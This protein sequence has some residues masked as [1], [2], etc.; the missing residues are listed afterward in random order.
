MGTVHRAYDTSL[1]RP[2]A[3]KFLRSDDPDRVQRFLREAQAQARVEHENVCRVYESGQKDG[4][5]YIAMQL[6]DGQP[7]FV[8]D[9]EASRPSPTLQG[10]SVEQKV[11]LMQQIAEAIQA[12]HREGLIHR[13]I[14]PSNI[15]L[16]RH[17]DGRLQPYVLDFGLARE[18][19]AAGVTSLGLA[20]GTPNFMSPEQARGE[21]GALDRRTDV[22][23]LGATLYAL[24]AGAPPFEGPS[25]LDVL[26]KVTEQDAPP[27]RGVPDDLATIVGKCLQKDPAH[28]YDSARALAEDL[29]RYLDGEPIHARKTSLAY[30]LLKKARKHRKLVAAGGVAL[31]AFL[32][33][34][35]TSLRAQLRAQER[36]RLAGVFGQEVKAIESL[37]RI[38]QL[39]PEHD[40]RTEKAAIRQ[41]MAAID[42]QVQRLGR[43]AQGPGEYALGRGN[44]ALMEYDSARTHLERA[45]AS[46][47]REPE[48]AYALGCVMGALYGRELDAALKLAPKEREARRRQAEQTYRDPAVAYLQQSRGVDVESPEYA[49]ALVALYEKRYP[50]ALRS[51][52]AAAARLPWLHEARELE[53][54]I[55]EAMGHEELLRGDNDLGAENRLQAEA[56]Y[57]A[58]LDVGRSN[59]VIPERLCRVLGDR[60]AAALY[61][62]SG[63]M[64]PL[65]AQA[66]EMCD[67]ALRVDPESATAYAAKASLLCRMA[68]ARTRA[69]E[70]PTELVTEAVASGREVV[71]LRPDDADSYANIGYALRIQ[72]DWDKDRDV[73]PLLEEAI[74]VYDKA[75]VLEPR[76]SRILLL[77]GNNYYTLGQYRASRGQNPRQAWAQAEGYYARTVD[78]EAGYRDFNLAAVHAEGAAWELEHGQDPAAVLDQALDAAQKALAVDPTNT[79]SLSAVAAVYQHRAERALALGEDPRPSIDEMVSCAKAGLKSDPKDED[80]HLEMTTAATLRARFALERGENAEPILQEGRGWAAA[81]RGVSATP[82]ARSVEARLALVEARWRVTRGLDPSLA[83]ARGERA[84]REAL[85]TKPNDPEAHAD[86]AELR[87]RLAQGQR[88]KG[89]SAAAAIDGGLEAAAKVLAFNPHHA[90]ALAVQGMLHLERAEVAQA[91]ESLEQAFAINRFLSREYGPVLEKVRGRLR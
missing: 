57:R 44:L 52:R 24:F 43:V 41:R 80:G 14:K 38:A 55:L 39:A 76:S 45:W 9:G 16:E 34:G 64:E 11:R 21:S 91:C 23:G 30:R 31:A 83:V 59:P 47:Y 73:L 19:A 72:V 13:D 28:R 81:L 20:A 42:A 7:L 12:A 75:L 35:A 89:P 4:R 74:R 3:L 48:V 5:P 70:D 15:M 40:L 68:E 85:R 82:V 90:R 29:G 61:G 51:A 8:S 56:A 62:K 25:S 46:G 60:A 58:G 10:M 2:V 1:K 86:L 79:W 63:P 49:L 78:L 88:G 27:L 36:A 33:L 37:M 84:L 71:R 22:Y 54:R 32:A 77:Q 26:M 50:D 65:F 66:R 69:G 53:G 87:W 6:I 67:R 17:E 18:V